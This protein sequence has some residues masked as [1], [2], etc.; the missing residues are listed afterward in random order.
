MT[1]DTSHAV[2]YFLFIFV[3]FQRP[4]KLEMLVCYCE[5]KSCA[6]KSSSMRMANSEG[7]KRWG[8][9]NM[10]LT[11]NKLIAGTLNWQCLSLGEE[12]FE[13]TAHQ[14]RGKSENPPEH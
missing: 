13:V 6:S 12:G 14:A 3:G 9:M 10:R 7:E 4:C 5:A 11:N 1:F 2:E 8:R